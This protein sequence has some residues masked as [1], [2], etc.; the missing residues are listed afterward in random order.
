MLIFVDGSLLVHR[1]QRETRNRYQQLENIPYLVV[2]QK[3][4]GRMSYGGVRYDDIR[5]RVS[6]FRLSVVLAA[7]LVLM[8]IVAI[9]RGPL[10]HFRRRRRGLCGRCG[11][12]LE[13]NVTGVCPECGSGS[14]K[15][16]ATGKR[17]TP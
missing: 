12:N 4:L 2:G 7:P 9:I 3:L 16:N 10:R 15:T 6:P 1:L 14:P 17:R 11:Y 13:G 8:T 5:V